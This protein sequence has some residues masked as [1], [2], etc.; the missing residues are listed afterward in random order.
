MAM[1]TQRRLAGLLEG[2]LKGRTRSQELFSH[3]TAKQGQQPPSPGIAFGGRGLYCCDSFMPLLK[4]QERSQNHGVLLF[5][6]L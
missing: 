2:R 6:E 1:G 4:A 3:S 5:K